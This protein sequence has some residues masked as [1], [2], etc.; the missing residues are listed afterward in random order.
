MT[1]STEAME[2][3]GSRI[4][5]AGKMTGLSSVPKNLRAG[6]MNAKAILD[7]GEDSLPDMLIL[8]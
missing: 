7:F 6:K 1:R 5:P 4:Y 2:V 3:T 8:A